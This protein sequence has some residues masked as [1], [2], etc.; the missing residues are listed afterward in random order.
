M[1]RARKLFN[2][3]NVLKSCF[4]AYVLLSLEYCAPLWMSSV[5][6]HLSL[7]D[8]IVRSGESLCGGEFCRLG[9]RKK[10]NW[11]CSTKFITEW[12]TL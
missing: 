4:N 5:K 10:A 2:C 11:V 7:L 12:I 9:H 3:L 6:D 8:S 1:R